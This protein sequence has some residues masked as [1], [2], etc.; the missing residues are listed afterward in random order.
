MSLAMCVTLQNPDWGQCTGA[1]KPRQKQGNHDVQ[2]LEICLCFLDNACVH[3]IV[4][5][6]DCF[7]VS[8]L[9]L[10]MTSIWVS[11]ERG[12][13]PYTGSLKLCTRK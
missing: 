11:K 4:M 9:C 2:V 8:E 7:V 13:S 12:L 6:I 3:A 5:L 10:K 1:W